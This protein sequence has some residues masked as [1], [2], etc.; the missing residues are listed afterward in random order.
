MTPDKAAVV[1]ASQA[2]V[3]VRSWPSLAR[4]AMLPTEMA[5]VHDLAFSPDGKILA[6]VGGH[7]AVEGGVELYRWPEQDLLRRVSPHDDVVYAVAWRQDGQELALA[8]GDNRVSVVAISIERASHYLEGHSRAVLAVAYL[9]KDNGLLSGGVDQSIRLW[10]VT[11]TTT[12][13]T[14]VNHTRAVTDLKVRPSSDSQTI[15]I[16]ASSGEDRTVRF[17][18]PTIGRLVRFARLESPALELAWNHDGQILW[19]ACRDGR[20]RAVNPENAAVVSDLPAVDG[21]AYAVAISP[22]E[23]LLVAGSN[24]QLRRV[25]IHTQ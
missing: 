6:V 10:D 2:G 8:G 3:E 25:V 14:L 7:P 16:V 17:W 1:V 5:N 12:K 11:A 9:P 15:P 22:D 23:K 13:R 18:Q 24:G 4:V 20:V 21:V 19:A